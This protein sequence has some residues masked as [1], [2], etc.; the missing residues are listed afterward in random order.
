MK[1]DIV[2]LTD[3][4]HIL[5]RPAMYIGAVDATES[6]EYILENNKVELKTVKF[7]QALVKIINEIIDN[8]VDAAIKSNFKDCNKITIKS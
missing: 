8:S 7:V 6:E 5:K 4:E 2:E 3:R 1:N